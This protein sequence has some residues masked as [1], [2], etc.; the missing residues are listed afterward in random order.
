MGSLLGKYL[1]AGDLLIDLAWN[2]DCCEIVQWCHDHGVLYINTSVGALGSLRRGRQQAPHRT[3]PLLA[4]HESAADDGRRG[5]ARSHRRARAR[6]QPRPDLPFH[7]AGACWTSPSAALA[8]RKFDGAAGGEVA[9][10]AEP[11]TFN[12]LAHELGVKV[13]HCSE[14]DTQIA[15]PAQEVNEFVNTWSVEGFRE[16]GTTTAEMG[17]GTHEKELPAAGLRARRRPEEPDLPGPDGHQHVRGARGCPEL[18]DQ[19]HG[20]PPRRS[21]H[22]LRQADR[23]GGRQGALPPDGSLR[24]LPGDARHRVA[25]RAARPR[26]RAAAE[27]PHHDTT[28]SSAGPTSWAPC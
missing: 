17:W 8:D 2:I 16:E 3:D 22:H 13:I 26:L 1:S 6:R 24:L 25:V 19:R 28:R 9:H 11:Q 15:R 10:H 4:P 27:H 23:L 12:H 7:Q 14:R 20:R 5:R 21:V 18:H